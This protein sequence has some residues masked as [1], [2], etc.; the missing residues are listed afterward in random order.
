LTPLPTCFPAR[1]AT[2]LAHLR[3]QLHQAYQANRTATLR[4]VAGLTP[5][6]LTRQVHPDYSPIGWH[7][8]HIGFTEERWILAHLAQRPRTALTYQTPQFQRLFAADG[9]PKA[10][11]E[12][13]PTLAQLC[14]AL[15]EIR[16]Q[17]LDYLAVAPLALE[18]RWWYWLLQHEAQHGETMAILRQLQRQ[19]AMPGL[20]GSAG[21]LQAA[22]VI[23]PGAI[24]VTEMMLIPAGPFWQGCNHSFVL[25]NETPAHRVDLPDYQIDRYPVTRG[26]FRQFMAAGGYQNPAWWSAAGWAWLQTQQIDAPLYWQMAAADPQGED[27]PVC[28]VSWYEADAYARFVGK[29]LPSEAEWEK[30]AQAMLTPNAPLPSLYPWGD[31]PPNFQQ[32]NHSHQWG[33]TTPVG[34]FPAGASGF[35][36]E[37]M[38]GN[39]WEWTASLFQPYPEFTPFPYP[40]YSAAYFDQQH[41][42]LRGGSW[43]TQAVALRNSFRNWYF[44]HTREIFAGFRCA[45]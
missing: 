13:L 31:T 45:V 15:A 10:E 43:A 40:G 28:G 9:L 38:F 3:Q 7:L 23:A 16:A 29:R 35:G 20:S 37:E 30:A 26:Q 24:P 39:V 42:V 5:S 4:L 8:G 19:T 22:P 25:D 32:G 41:Y 2:D 21:R 12:N 34:E 11:R 14:T 27:H 6:Q 18:L 17:V 36:V 33:Q 44:P 1:E